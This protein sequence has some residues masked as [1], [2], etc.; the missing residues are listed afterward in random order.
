[1]IEK[2]VSAEGIESANKRRFRYLQSTDGTQSTWKCMVIRLNGLQMDCSDN[3]PWLTAATH[4][5]GFGV[6]ISVPDIY[7]CFDA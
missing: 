5:S 4:N 7:D 2:M 6:V 3:L 1:V